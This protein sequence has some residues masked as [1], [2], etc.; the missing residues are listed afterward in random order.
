MKLYGKP[1]YIKTRLSITLMKNYLGATCVQASE[2]SLNALTSMLIIT[3]AANKNS[4]KAISPAGPGSISFG[5]DSASN[6]C[7]F[8]K[9]S[10]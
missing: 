4:K 6:R 8:N 3:Q 1:D 10:T 9:Y 7:T 5:F 2:I